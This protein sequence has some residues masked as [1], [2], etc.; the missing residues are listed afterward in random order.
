MQTD[1]VMTAALVNSRSRS[2]DVIV[3]KNTLQYIHM[4]IQDNILRIFQKFWENGQSD[5]FANDSRYFIRADIDI[6]QYGQR[7]WLAF[8][9]HLP[10]VFRMSL[11]LKESMFPAFRDVMVMNCRMI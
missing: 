8:V 9:T 3:I 11:S 2:S 7:I 10:T 6:I 4:F 5:L 1:D